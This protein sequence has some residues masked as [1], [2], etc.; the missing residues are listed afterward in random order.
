MK[1]FC[2]F[3]IMSYTK[4]LLSFLS[5]LSTHYQRTNK[6]IITLCVS[7]IIQE[8]YKLITL[9]MIWQEVGVESVEQMMD[10]LHRHTQRTWATNTLLCLSHTRECCKHNSTEWHRCF[11]VERVL[12]PSYMLCM[13]LHCTDLHRVVLWTLY[14][15]TSLLKHYSLAVWSLQRS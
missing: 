3:Y 9:W 15:T 11:S 6:G 12:N 4:L 10:R 8:L 7:V 1:V 2:Q 13:I 14:L 5:T